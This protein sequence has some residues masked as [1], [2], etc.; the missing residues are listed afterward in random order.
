M[1]LPTVCP[2]CG[3]KF[4]NDYWTE[5]MIP[6]TPDEQVVTCPKC[7]KEF[8]G[9]VSMTVEYEVEEWPYEEEDEK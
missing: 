1:K 5:D 7:K 8:C 9:E 6:G 3:H 4:Q 2:H